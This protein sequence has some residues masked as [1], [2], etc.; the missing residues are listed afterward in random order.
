VS[1]DVESARPHRTRVALVLFVLTCLSVFWVGAITSGAVEARGN[2]ALWEGYPFALPFLAILVCHELGHYVAAR[3]HGIDASPPYFLPLPLPPIGT[4]GAVIGMSDPIRRRDALF[5]VGV[6]GPLSGL[7]IAVPVLIY[8]LYTS[9]VQA[10]DPGVTY[11]LEGRSLLYLAVLY[12]LKGS[13]PA[14]HDV[15]LN[16]PA[17]AGWAG[18][19]VTMMNLVPAGQLDG[20]HVAYALFGPRQDVYSRRVRQALFVFGGC[21]IAYGAWEARHAQHALPSMLASSS[22]LLWAAL[23]TGMS[24]VFGAQHPPTDEAPLSPVRRVM[25]WLCLLLFLL[26]FMPRWLVPSV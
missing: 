10:L 20:G 9:P 2:W 4:L 14:G 16:A 25:A 15:M 1:D 5:D 12:G 23:L 26:L 22:W 21:M 8:G 18:L 17:F 11:D 13:I 3:V 6:A 24:R 19:L 7:V